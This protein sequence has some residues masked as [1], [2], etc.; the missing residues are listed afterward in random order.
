MS[1]PLLDIVAR[2]KKD[3]EE[4]GNDIDK[5]YSEIVELVN[6][7]RLQLNAALDGT[8]INWSAIN[9]IRSSMEE[10]EITIKEM[11]KK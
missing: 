9:R 1:S 11:L 3:L 4:I 8:A 2:I 5:N 7:W 10:F 6:A